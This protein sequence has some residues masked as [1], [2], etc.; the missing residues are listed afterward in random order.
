M[1]SFA[2]RRHS[3]KNGAVS[4]VDKKFISHP[5]WTQQNCQQRKLSKFLM[6]YEQFVSHSYCWGRRTS[7][8]YGVAAGEGFPSVPF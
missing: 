4:K 1:F 5:T 7:F 8:Q 2:F 6:R 3:Q